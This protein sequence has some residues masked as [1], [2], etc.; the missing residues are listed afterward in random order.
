[1]WD[2]HGFSMDEVVGITQLWMIRGGL[3]MTVTSISVNSPQCC[4]QFCWS[5]C[6]QNHCP[7]LSWWRSVWLTDYSGFSFFYKNSVASNTVFA[8]CHSPPKNPI[9]IFLPWFPTGFL[10]DLVL[11]VLILYCLHLWLQWI[12]VSSSSLTQKAAP[13][14][15]L[16][17]LN[18]FQT[19][20]QHSHGND[21]KSSQ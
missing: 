6:K 21:N 5:P 16:C 8:L 19:V 14:T 17:N 18:E 15:L 2:I 11:F 7:E 3:N 1:M 12:A 4:I 9:L 20:F 10:A 13:C